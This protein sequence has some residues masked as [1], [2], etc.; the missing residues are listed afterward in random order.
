VSASHLRDS[1][2]SYWHRYLEFYEQQLRDITC[3]SVLEF[4]VWRGASIRWLRERFPAA[5]LFG[6]DIMEQQPDWPRDERIRYLRA[7]QGQPA[8]L[9]SI[10]NTID[11]RLD[12]VIDDGSHIPLHQRNCLMAALP[13]MNAGSRYILE[14]IHTSHPDHPYF[15]RAKPW[16]G[17]L[18]GVLH[19]LLALEH[20]K[21]RAAALDPGALT[22]LS[23]RSL[24]TAAD[25]GVLFESV[26]SV[27]FYKRACLP[28]RCFRCETSNFDFGRLRCSCGV[29]LYSSSDSMS[30]VICLK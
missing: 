10:F 13:H 18:V 9:D 27:S 3:E 6:C 24:F 21:A 7:D 26:R 17:N 2:K 29:D 23:R 15:R 20:L 12:L 4:G 14:D 30:A 22:A 5:R 8:Q 16:F 25:I 1:D 28:I 19:V 11:R